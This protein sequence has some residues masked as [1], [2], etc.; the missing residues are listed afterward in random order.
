MASKF[1]N[2][3]IQHECGCMHIHNFKA[4]WK[5]DESD[6]SPPAKKIRKTRTES[7]K[8]VKKLVAPCKA[9]KKKILP[10]SDEDEPFEE[11]SK[12]PIAVINIPV[13]DEIREDLQNSQP[14]KPISLWDIV[15]E[16]TEEGEEVDG[17]EVS[18]S[19]RLYGFNNHEVIMSDNDRQTLETITRQIRGEVKINQLR[20]IAVDQCQSCCSLYHCPFCSEASEAAS[21]LLHLVNSHWAKRFSLAGHS[22][23]RCMCEGSAAHWHC[24]LCTV[25]MADEPSSFLQHFLAHDSNQQKVVE[26]VVKQPAQASEAFQAVAV[27]LA[28]EFLQRLPITT[29][30]FCQILQRT[31]GVQCSLLPGETSQGLIQ[32]SWAQVQ[33]SKAIIE[34]IAQLETPTEE[35]VMQIMQALN[36]NE[37]TI[38]E[39]GLEESNEVEELVKIEM[40]SEEEEEEEEEE[41]VVKEEVQEVQEVQI[42][43]IEEKKVK[44]KEECP[45]CDKSFR[46][47]WGLLPHVT[48]THAK[49]TADVAGADRLLP[50]LQSMREIEGSSCPRCAKNFKNPREGQ[51]HYALESC[52]KRQPTRLLAASLE[53]NQDGVYMCAQC[54]YTNKNA[55]NVLNHQERMHMERNVPCT[56]CGAMLSS[57]RMLDLHIKQKHIYGGRMVVCDMCGTEVTQSYLKKHKQLMHDPTYVKV[58]KP[59][60]EYIPCPECDY[61]APKQCLLQKHVMRMHKERKLCCSQCHA[62]FALEYDLRLHMKNIHQSDQLNALVKCEKCGKEMKQRNLEHHM[63]NVHNP[64]TQHICPHCDKALCS[65]HSLK[66]HIM[67]AHTEPEHREYKFTC[68]KCGAGFVNKTV[69]ND[70]LNTHTGKRPYHCEVCGKHFRQMSTFHTHVQTHRDVVYQCAVCEETFSS[71]SAL[72][73]HMRVHESWQSVLEDDVIVKIEG[74]DEGAGEAGVDGGEVVENQAF[75]CAYCQA[76]FMTMDEAQQHMVTVHADC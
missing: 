8:K 32:G 13:D 44:F 43:K 50:L 64:R 29:E 57:Q 51:V 72:T 11:T 68:E 28:T 62:R 23:L 36:G 38:V 67:F 26:A 24:P 16:W 47:L 18:P 19:V 56:Q 10:C 17:I 9:K 2:Y 22:M 5:S 73:T 25:C 27:I 6:Q 66:V 14:E 20:D 74:Q 3:D 58:V 63:K 70:H 45:L 71:R 48:L 39:I 75:L 52:V 31:T 54:A 33:S 69:Y 41:E 61:Q 4:Y 53:K 30:K 15:Q 49:I 46:S 65:K 34:S 7:P 40:M 42:E 37:T 21:I 35:D 76:I 55:K 1:G 60:E 59:K 12:K